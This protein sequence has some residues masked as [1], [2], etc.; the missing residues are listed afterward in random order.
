MTFIP[1]HFIVIVPGFMGSKLSDPNS[2]EMVWGDFTSMPLNPFEWNRWLDSKLDRL[3]YPSKLE[4]AG[5]MDEVLF[6]LPWAKQEEYSRLVENL[7]GIGYNI[8]PANP[9]EKEPTAYTFAYDWRQDN[10]ISA[11][12]LSEAIERWRANHSGAKAWII[13]HSNGGLVARWYIE[14]EGGKEHVGRLLLMASPWDGAPM[15]MQ[16]LFSGLNTLLRG[17]FNRFLNIPQ[18]TRDLVSTFPSIYQL[19]PYKK[20]FLIDVNSQHVDLSTGNWLDSEQQRQMLLDAQRFYEELGTTASAEE[21][22]CFFG[23]KQPTIT[24][25]VVH[26]S[27]A[28]RWSKIEWRDKEVGDGTVPERSAAHPKVLQ[29]FPVVGGHGDI[30]VLDAVRETLQ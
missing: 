18:R 5:I 11:R 29:K 10:R 14:K 2:G 6:V 21:T 30:Y 24:F 28:G 26:F 16:V 9:L 15:A 19:L 13:A 27:A 25:G 23:R 4:P 20:P 7:K 12:Q 17:Y 22:L 8:D 3:K 1:P